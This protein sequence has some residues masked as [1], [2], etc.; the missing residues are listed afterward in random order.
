MKQL[1]CHN[2]CCIILL[3]ILVVL[4]P[5]SSLVYAQRTVGVQVGDW[6]EYT[7]AF[8]SEG[9]FTDLED[10]FEFETITGIRIA[11]VDIAETNVTQEAHI[12]FANGS[13][14]VHPGWVDIETGDGGGEATFP[15]IAGNLV[16]GDRIYTNNETMFGEFTINETLTRSYL[17]STFEVN[18]WN[19]NVT[20]PPNPFLNS[21]IVFDIYWFRDSGFPAEIRMFM[22]MEMMGNRT[23][24]DMS[25]NI[26]GIIPEFPSTLVL[27]L[28]IAG[29]LVAVL[30]SRRRKFLKSR[31][32]LAT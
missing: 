10:P 5:T 12:Y 15:L 17:G 13:D 7:I 27:P 19:S 1:K 21:S 25:M 16:E 6:A 8:T 32:C 2:F 11:V 18:R 26:I 22:M 9:N 4:I 28:L 31:C 23:S 30:L 14:S 29:T 3:G 20:A 24:I